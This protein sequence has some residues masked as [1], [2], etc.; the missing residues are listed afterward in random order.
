[1]AR[2]VYVVRHGEAVDGVLSAAGRE[3]ARL[4]GQ[5]L[6]NVAVERIHHSPLPRAAETAALISEHLPGVPVE[7]SDVVGDYLPPPPDAELLQQLPPGYAALLGDATEAELAAGADLADAALARFAVATAA[8][9]RDVI[10][11]HNQ[12]AGWFV[13]HTLDA[14]AWRWMG[15]NQCNGALTTLLYRPNRPPALLTFNDMSH[16]PE[17]L[18]WTGFPPELRA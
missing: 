12:I 1:M 9:T 16:L 6:A 13:R 8:D 10:V 18:Q 2:R 14:P 3:Q 4:V 7:V 5:R 15:L 11:T 17:S